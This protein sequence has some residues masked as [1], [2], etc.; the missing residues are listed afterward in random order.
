MWTLAGF[1]YVAFVVDVFSRR[2]LGWK[3]SMSKRTELVTGALAQAL[4]TR[5]RTDSTFTATGL[6]HHSDAGSQ[7]TSIAFTQALID[8][9]IA[10]S[11]GSVGDAL[12]NALME[13]T[14]GLYKT[15]LVDQQTGH[16]HRPQPRRTRDRRLGPLVQHRTAALVHRLPAIAVIDTATKTRPTPTPSSSNPGK[17]SVAN[18]ASTGAVDNQ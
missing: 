2:I 9:D 6:V 7:Y 3:A 1:C 13:S 11:I 18:R 10:G 8:A 17:R 4:F 14:I 5:R 15:E 16:L 12:D